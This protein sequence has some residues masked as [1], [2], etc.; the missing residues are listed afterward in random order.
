MLLEKPGPS[1]VASGTFLG[2]PAKQATIVTLTIQSSALILVMHYSRIMKPDGDHKYFPS[3][4][5]FLNEVIKLAIS[6]TFSL[7]EVS[8]TLA[9]ST[10]ATTIFEQIYRSVFSGDCWKLA[11]PALLYTLQ[12]TL[13]YV[14]LSNLD[15]V[16]Y[17]VLY[18]LKI[19]TTAVFSVVLLGKSIAFK[20]WLAL[21][22]LTAGVSI[23]S[24]P[25]G[26]NSPDA[27]LFHDTSDHWFP[28]SVHELG[29]MA[30]GAGDAARELTRRSFEV[31]AGEIVKRSA[32]YEGIDDDMDAPVVMNSSMGIAAV[33][34]AAV[35]SGLAGV[36]FEK[37]LKE[38]Q[39]G[40]SVWTRNIQLSFFSLF[41][42]LFLGI[43]YTDGADISKHGFFDG[44]NWV[45]WM[46][47]GLQAVGG[48]L[49]SLCINYADNIAKNYATSVSIVISFICSMWFF[50]FQADFTVLGGAAMVLLSAWAY[51]MADNKIARR[52]TPI[53]VAS[54]EKMIVDRLQTPR[55]LDQHKL[56][57]NPMDSLSP[58]GLSSSR[59]ASPMIGRIPSSA[60][61]GFED[62]EN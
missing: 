15:P 26:E 60:R 61:R 48:I 55:Q 43:I 8:R 47:I 14:A 36:Y 62:H 52:P 39:S 34:I 42:A 20:R 51:T 18:E 9:P 33:V 1:R 54:L 56:N 27:L 5:V 11:I 22:T 3:T 45:V 17:Q 29:Q 21:I 57:V 58:A 46:A 2:L 50:D 23:V 7:W 19:L 35:I 38:S 31:A 13:Q 25:L 6:L 10:P 28:R 24:L 16:H 49:A 41:P 4:A 30:N 44:Y 40:I 37:I 12:N 32:T 53:R 59:P